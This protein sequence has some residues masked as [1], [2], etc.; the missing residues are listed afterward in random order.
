[1][2][3]GSQPGLVR[4]GAMAPQTPASVIREVC[5]VPRLVLDRYLL[6]LSPRVHGLGFR[7]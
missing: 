2:G 3:L 6:G 1:M 4:S 5:P 7:V